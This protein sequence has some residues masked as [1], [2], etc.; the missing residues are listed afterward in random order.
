MAI[1]SDVRDEREDD[2]PAGELPTSAAPVED[3]ALRTPRW[4][5]VAAVVAGAM[6]VIGALVNAAVTLVAPGA[7]ADLDEWLGSPGFAAS[8]W[9]ATLGSNPRV[10]VPLVGVGF[11]LA[12][13]LLCLTRERRRRALGLTGAT[14]FHVALLVMGLWFWALPWALIFGGAAWATWRVARR[15]PRGSTD[16][17]PLTHA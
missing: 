8:I 2:A 17:V 14:V 12:I 3:L 5:V 4:A 11:E 13:G 15:T 10:W 16:D 6:F 7:Y 1:P 9:D